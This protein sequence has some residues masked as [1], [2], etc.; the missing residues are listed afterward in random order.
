MSGRNLFLL[1]FI[2]VNP[3][4]SFFYRVPC[5]FVTSG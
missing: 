1:V 2:C 5:D 4:L 3:W